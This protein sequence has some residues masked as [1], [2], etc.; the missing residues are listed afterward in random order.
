M[1][2]WLDSAGYGTATFAPFHEAQLAI[3]RQAN[4]QVTVKVESGDLQTHVVAGTPPDFL[5]TSYQTMYQYQQQGAL[6]PIDAYLDRRGKA[7]FYD[8][9]R[10]ISTIGGKMYEWP[11]M[12]NPVGPVVNR[13]LFK[14]KNLDSLLP[15]P[16]LKADWTFEQWKAALKAVTTVTGDAERDVYGTAWA[17]RTTTGDYYMWMYQWSNGADLFD[18]EQ[19]KVTLNSPEGIAALQMLVDAVTRER[20]ARPEPWNDD[21]AALRRCTSASGRPSSTARRRTSA[22]SRPGSRAGASSPR[23]RRSSCRCP[24]RRARNRARSSPPNPS[25]S[26]GSPATWTAPGRR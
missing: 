3:F 7:D 18:K 21:T 4:P 23:S 2:A 22:T 10:E 9:P 17:A 15:Q 26:S 5:R 12:L 16:G 1:V 11:W 13:S 25:S 20:L 8:W 6:E 14:E 24:T 19:T